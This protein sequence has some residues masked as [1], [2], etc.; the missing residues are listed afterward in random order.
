MATKMKTRKAAAKRYSFTAKG[1]VK[2][3]KTG[4]R[5]LLSSKS[6]KS[7]RKKGKANY[8]HSGLI[9]AVEV[10]LPYGTR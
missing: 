9:G 3:R 1:K 8:V 7:K 2:V 6:S 4:L 10:N 5:H